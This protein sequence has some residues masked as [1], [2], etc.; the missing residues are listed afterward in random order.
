MLGG[1][2]RGSRSVGNSEVVVSEG[3]KNFRKFSPFY[4]IPPINEISFF[5]GMEHQAGH[6][7]Q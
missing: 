3:V 2:R 4:S 1:G 6:E 7:G 5:V